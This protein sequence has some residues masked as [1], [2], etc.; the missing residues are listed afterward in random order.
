IDTEQARTTGIDHHE[1]AEARAQWAQ[2]I[3]RVADAF[4]V[5]PALLER[6]RAW[7]AEDSYWP[8]FSVLTHGEIYPAHTLVDGERVTAVLD[9]TTA[10]VGDPA[11]DLQFQ[12]SV[13]P[14]EAFEVLLDHY[15]RGGGR[16][17]PRLGEHCT[18]MFAASPL[19]Y[20][21]YALETGDPDHREAAEAQLNPPRSWPRWSLSRRA[22]TGSEERLVLGRDGVDVVGVVVVGLDPLLDVGAHR[23]HP[24]ALRH[25]L[26]D[27]LA[28]QGRGQAAPAERLAD[29]G[30]EQDPLRG[31]LGLGVEVLREAGELPI[32]GDL[33][34]GFL[35]IVVHSGHIGHG[36][37]LLMVAALAATVVPGLFDDGTA[38]C[39]RRVHGLVE[40]P[41]PCQLRS[42]P[43]LPVKAPC[44]PDRSS[45]CSPP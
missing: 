42:G 14:P 28:G 36:R 15:V 44:S 8:D 40:R 7:V 13:S 33:V 1:P 35:R 38:D 25:G 2:D 4:D 21:L 22:T 41:E 10:A 26:A 27:R 9:W 6:W 18:E 23:H 19:G 37:S 29:L 45:A 11:R 20:G 39:S 31:P 12:H 24:L 17:W 30:V 3:D 43:P 32:H 16:V 34:T 5:A